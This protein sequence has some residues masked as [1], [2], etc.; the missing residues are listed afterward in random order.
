MTQEKLFIIISG[1]IP[2]IM[3]FLQAK[4][5]KKLAYKTSNENLPSFDEVF[6]DY[7]QQLASIN[8][9]VERQ[10]LLVSSPYA[11]LTEV[12]V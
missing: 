1:L 11:Y 7:Q 12:E 9:Q 10:P 3:P 4:P 2:V 8:T 5:M 6:Q